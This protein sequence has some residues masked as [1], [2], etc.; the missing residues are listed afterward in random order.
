MRYYKTTTCFGTEMPS[1][2]RRSIQRNVGPTHQSSYVAL[3]EVIEILNIE[4]LKYI[5]LITV[6][7]QCCNINS[8]KS[9]KSKPFATIWISDV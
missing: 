9:V 1:S 7:L 5:K 8:S 4:V 2:G 3:T 6:N